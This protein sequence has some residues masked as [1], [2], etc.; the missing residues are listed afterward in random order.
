MPPR[1]QGGGICAIAHD[2]APGQKAASQIVSPESSTRMTSGADL[3]YAIPV[4]DQ[5]PAREDPTPC[6]AGYDKIM[7]LPVSI[8]IS[9]SNMAKPPAVVDADTSLTRGSDARCITCAPLKGKLA[10]HILC[11]SQHDGAHFEAYLLTF[12][13]IGTSHAKKPASR[14]PTPIQLR[15]GCASCSLRCLIGAVSIWAE[16]E[17]RKSD[18]VA[19]STLQTPVAARPL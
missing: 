6:A 11:K 9:R 8:S 19:S 13:L 14:G 16:V 4:N 2:H 17:A 3:C 18:L 10:L 12:A 1:R 7:T 15:K 5:L